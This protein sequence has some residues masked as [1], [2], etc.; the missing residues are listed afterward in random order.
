MHHISYMTS[1][2]IEKEN[3]E[4]VKAYKELLKVSTIP[5]INTITTPTK[6]QKIAPYITKSQ[7]NN[8][9]QLQAIK[10]L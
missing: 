8:V 6:E 3:A 5:N 2:E 10:T 4:I 7:K 1:F 9:L